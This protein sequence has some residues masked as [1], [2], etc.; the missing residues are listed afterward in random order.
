MRFRGLIAALVAAMLVITVNGTTPAAAD[1]PAGTFTDL[2]PTVTSLT[3][4]EGTYGKCPGGSDCVYAVV[5]GD[6]TKLNIIDVRSRELIKTIALPG[7]SGGWGATTASDGS[8]Y[9]GSYNNGRLYRYEP[10]ADRMTDLGQP[11]PGEGLLYHL[12]PG[13]DGTIFGGTYP[14]AHLFSYSP[15]KGVTDFGRM[16][17][18]QNYVR[19]VAY[20]HDHG[21]LFAGIGAR[22]GL[23]RIDLATGERTDVLPEAL[24][25]YAFVYDL[26]YAGGRLLIKVHNGPDIKLAVMDPVSGELIPIKDE[27]TGQTVDRVP[28]ASRGTAPLAPDGRSVYYT[29]AGGLWVYDLETST[30]RPI[31]I[32]GAPAAVDGA[33][34]GF[35][36]L[37][38]AEDPSRQVLYGLAG[39]YAGRAFTFDP[40]APTLERYSLSFAPVPVDLSQLYAGADGDGKVYTSAYI[41]GDLGVY[42]PATETLQQFPRLGQ[43]EGWTWYEGK[44]YIGTYPTGSLREYDPKSPWGSGNPKLLVSLADEHK[45]NRPTAM[46]A[47]DGKLYAGTTPDYGEHGGALTVVDLASGQVQVHRHIVENQTVSSIALLDGVLYG[48]TSIA[49]GGGTDPIATEA[50]LFTADPVT[51]EKTGEFAPV[52]GAYSI[53]ALLTGPD[54]NLWGLADG[55]LFVLDPKTHEVLSTTKIFDGTAGE[56]DGDLVIVGGEYVYG[57]SGARLFRIDPLSQQATM[58]SQGGTRRLTVDPR[59]DLYLLHDGDGTN[60]N[61]LLRYRPAADAC[62][63]SDLRPKV[64]TGAVDSGV[65]NRYTDDGCTVNDLILDDRDWPTR[66]RFVAHVAGVAEELTAAG[67]ITEAEAD[68]LAAAAAR[69]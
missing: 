59:G 16:D 63:D 64:F 1:P 39:N 46:A 5:A 32:D 38:S 37:P 48:G 51:G 22:A 45:Q 18:E 40:Q 13:P 67:V 23:V 27:S 68:A 47:A 56:T 53:N 58:I 2:G 34:I 6:N 12:V 8:I 33:G 25:G 9:I 24:A 20:D 26:D 49:G 61:R 65:G 35:S 3:V 42:D 29:A 69:S 7:A 66:G 50:K 62:P 41:N 57:H 17:P 31:L 4:M 44:L 52:P 10:A 55:T 15:T 14:N 36:W 30:T 21:Y 43:V 19:S 54:G 28:I 11:I 60:I